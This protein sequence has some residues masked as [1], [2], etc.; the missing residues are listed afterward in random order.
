MS[1]GLTMFLAVEN[2]GANSEGQDVEVCPI[3]G[4]LRRVS[5]DVSDLAAPGVLSDVKFVLYR[6]GEQ[7]AP[8]KDYLFKPTIGAV[9]LA[10]FSHVK[11]GDRLVLKVINQNG[12]V[13]VRAVTALVDIEGYAD[14]R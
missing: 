12:T 14:K 9:S 6:N 5:F 8:H 11:K 13:A 4:I 3:D 10:A 1:I 7:I 2:L